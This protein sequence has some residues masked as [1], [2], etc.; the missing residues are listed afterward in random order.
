MGPIRSILVAVKD[1]TSRRLTIVSKAMQIAEGTGA[2]VELF[3][4]ISTPLLAD[5]YVYSPQKLA[6]AERAIRA[7][8]L[9]ALDGIASRLRRRGIT[10]A[11]SAEW[12]FPPYEAVVRR[13][14]RIGADLIVAETH[15]GR[16]IVPWLLHLTDWELLR[17]SPVPVLL[18]KN[19]R[20]YRRPAVLVAVDPSHAFAKTA[21]LDR[22]LLRVGG[23]ISDALRGT[24]H[25]VHAY[26]PI[27]PLM[28]T[29]LEPINP[30]VISSLES[31]ARLK[32]KAAFR[33]VLSPASIPAKRRHLVARPPIE[34]IPAAARKSRCAIVVMG[35]VSRSGLKRFFIGN[36]AERVLDELACDVLIVK[37]PHF[38]S[39]VGRARRGAQLTVSTPPIF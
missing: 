38:V 22:E 12:D 32:A 8:H 24:L 14:R 31:S 26:T 25:A 2:Q 36:T 6:Q 29:S 23:L 15:G 5:A 3:H 4:A 21:Q 30:N 18:V 16:H 37:P 34:A 27:P 10:T 17:L 1:P 13:A 7:R 11:V 28:S 9:A 33:R 20:P 39:R 35:A 19:A